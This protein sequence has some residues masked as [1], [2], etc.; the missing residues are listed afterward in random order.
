[1]VLVGK[2]GRGQF[3]QCFF[4]DA[5]LEVDHLAQRNPIVI[6]FPGLKFR[7]AG[8]FQVDI[9]VFTEKL[10]EEPN[11]LLAFVDAAKVA[12]NPAVGNVI[13]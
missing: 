12:A 11:L 4:I 6:P 9:F 1:M 7:M 3:F 5:A 10:Q 2:E 13:A 8:G